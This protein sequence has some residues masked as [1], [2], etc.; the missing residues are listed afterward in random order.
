M[1]GE[2]QACARVACL[3]LDQQPA[4]LSH[5]ADRHP[6][7]TTIDHNND[8]R[9][10]PTHT[11]DVDQ[12]ATLELAHS[13]LAPAPPHSRAIRHSF[14]IS[15]AIAGSTDVGPAQQGAH[16]AML[17]AVHTQSCTQPHKPAAHSWKAS[18]A[19]NSLA[20]Q[21]HLEARVLAVQGGI[22]VPRSLPAAGSGGEGREDVR[23]CCV[24]SCDCGCIWSW[25]CQ[26]GSARL[27][28]P[29]RQGT[30]IPPPTNTLYTQIHTHTCTCWRRT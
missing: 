2:G 18:P 29:G 4:V 12:V 9:A 15:S 30:H 27:A 5:P 10:A 21:L 23:G 13:H 20:G 17:S 26:G 28:V 1:V 19:T 3:S 8:A 24:C 14:M 7:T 22:H 16:A 11:P 6:T 25:Q